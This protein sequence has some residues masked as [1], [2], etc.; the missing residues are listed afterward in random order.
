MFTA[1]ECQ[2]RPELYCIAKAY[3]QQWHRG[4][5]RLLCVCQHLLMKLM[6]LQTHMKINLYLAF[7]EE[8]Q[9]TPCFSL[10]FNRPS[11]LCRS[12]VG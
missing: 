4:R 11:F 2:L 1:R 10:G 5:C 12:L 6:Y 8:N 7:P 3:R 9:V